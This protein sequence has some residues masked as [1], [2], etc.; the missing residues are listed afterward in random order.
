M[1]TSPTTI[2]LIVVTGPH[3]ADE[4][5]HTMDVFEPSKRLIHVD[6]EGLPTYQFYELTVDPEKFDL[7]KTVA[8]FRAHAAEGDAHLLA[9]FIPGE[10]G[11]FR[12]D[13]C[14]MVSTGRD[15]CLF[16]PLLRKWGFV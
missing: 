3:K 4:F 1:A 6:A 16:E 14:R 7:A 5:M 2:D 10:P 9:C 15:W 13:T 8:A 12:D 11:G